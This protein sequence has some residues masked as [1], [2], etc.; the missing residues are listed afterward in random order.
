[1]QNLHAG[2]CQFAHSTLNNLRFHKNLGSWQR[3]R[4]ALFVLLC[5]FLKW[6]LLRQGSWASLKLPLD[7]GQMTPP[8]PTIYKLNN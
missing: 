8:Q 3:G 2:H 6:V 7:N 4:V 1:M 5:P